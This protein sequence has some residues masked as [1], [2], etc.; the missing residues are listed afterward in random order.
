MV[1]YRLAKARVASS[2]LVIRSNFKLAVFVSFLFFNFN[3]V[4][5]E[6]YLLLEYNIQVQD[7]GVAQW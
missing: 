2:N 7:A 3:Y 5:V 1:E 6:K 4:L